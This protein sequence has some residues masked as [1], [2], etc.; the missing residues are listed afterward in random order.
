MIASRI[1]ADLF[2]APASLSE[3]LYKPAR[4]GG[5]DVASI[6]GARRNSVS[7]TRRGARIRLR[8]AERACS[9]PNEGR[10]E[11]WASGREVGTLGG[12]FRRRK[13]RYLSGQLRSSFRHR[14][15][16]QSNRV[17]GR[18]LNLGFADN[19]FTLVELFETS[20]AAKC[21]M[22]IFTLLRQ[23]QPT[24]FIATINSNFGISLALR[25]ALGYVM[26]C[27]MLQ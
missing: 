25:H 18:P 15:R 14:D 9:M 5:H 19:A 22:W 11:K 3:L 17:I 10:L 16:L 26:H 24:P 8:L 1:S 13:G 7:R 23:F 2:S 27:Q 12:G 4:F 21:G 20:F 6:R